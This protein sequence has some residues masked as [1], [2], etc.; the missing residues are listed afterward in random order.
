MRSVPN[1]LVE[2][3]YATGFG[4]SLTPFKFEVSIPTMLLV[5][6]SRYGDG[7]WLRIDAVVSVANPLVESRYG[8]GVWLRINA[9]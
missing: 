3:R 7:V 2:S 9:V 1:P 5:V 8:D 6:E 4:C